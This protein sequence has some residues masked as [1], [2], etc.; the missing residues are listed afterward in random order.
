MASML[1]RRLEEKALF[2]VLFRFN[3]GLL[4][5]LH[6]EWRQRFFPHLAEAVFS[7]PTA[8]FHLSRHLKETLGL[9]DVFEPEAAGLALAALPFARLHDLAVR[10]GI[11]AQASTLRHWLD[12]DHVHACREALGE[13]HWQF[14]LRHCQLIGRKETSPAKDIDVSTLWQQIRA[15]GQEKLWRIFRTQPSQIR[16][17]ARLKLPPALS[18]AD[19]SAHGAHRESDPLARPAFLPADPAGPSVP[20]EPSLKAENDDPL[21]LTREALRVVRHT[22]PEWYAL[23]SPYLPCP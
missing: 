8:Q 15:R 6:P 2:R 7:H 20:T 5:D 14:A 3:H 21:R 1:A 19:D 10:L 13:A 11:L 9:E 23:F 4:G 16:E 18:E 12:H 17:R 22:D